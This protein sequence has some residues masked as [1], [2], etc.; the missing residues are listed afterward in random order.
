MAKIEPNKIEQNPLRSPPEPEKIGA[1][2]RLIDPND[3]FSLFLFIF[4]AVWLTIW[5]G[6]SFP[7]FAIAI[8]EFIQKP[9]LATILIVAF[10]SIFVAIGVVSLIV[11]GSALYRV[12]KIKAGEIILPTYPLY[13]GETYRIKYRRKLRNGRTKKPTTVTAQW[14]NYE[15]VEYQQGTDTMTATHEISVI[16][17][18]EQ[19]IMAGVNELTYTAQITVPDDARLSIHAPHNQVRWELRIKIQIPLVAKD[20]SFFVVKVLPS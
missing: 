17:L 9:G 1:G 20:T 2:Y 5:C 3:G 16:D 10:I 14:V 7:I 19:S 13:Q 12:Y 8:V 11:A 15:W 6:V 4:G 18:P